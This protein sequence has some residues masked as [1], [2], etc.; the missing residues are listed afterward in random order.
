MPVI[1][2]EQYDLNIIFQRAYVF[3]YGEKGKFV[4]KV[5]GDEKLPDYEQT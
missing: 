4:I 1:A 5:G 2:H 3:L